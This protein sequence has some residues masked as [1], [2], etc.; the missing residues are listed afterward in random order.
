LYCFLIEPGAPDKREFLG[1]CS[2]IQRARRKQLKTRQKHNRTTEQGSE[3]EKA[4]LFAVK[5]L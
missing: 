5:V 3:Q 4:Q 1:V 2:D